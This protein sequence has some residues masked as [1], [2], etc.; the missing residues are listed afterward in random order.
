MILN[1]NRIFILLLTTLSG[2]TVFFSL[3]FFAKYTAQTQEQ[4]LNQYKKL[5]NSVVN[6]KALED[7]LKKNIMATGINIQKKI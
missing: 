6:L 3:S 4:N 2:L 1:K 5:S 7:I